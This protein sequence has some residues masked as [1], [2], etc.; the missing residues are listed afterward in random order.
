MGI[1]SKLWVC[2]D[3]IAS[4]IGSG[5]LVPLLLYEIIG[6]LRNLFM[7]MKKTRSFMIALETMKNLTFRL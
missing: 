4:K 1:Y 3:N 6:E 7:E 2:L 5:F